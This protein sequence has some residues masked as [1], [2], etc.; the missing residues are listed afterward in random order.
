[1]RA[2]QV[3]NIVSN[4]FNAAYDSVN[5][6]KSRGGNGD[7]TFFNAEGVQGI[8][9]M[10]QRAIMDDINDLEDCEVNEVVKEVVG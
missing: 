7:K 8:L 6:V 9:L 5:I 4:N 10:I 1:M 2:Y 3:R